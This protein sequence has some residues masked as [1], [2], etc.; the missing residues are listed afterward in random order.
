[1][2]KVLSVLNSASSMEEKKS[3]L[4][5]LVGG[6]MRSVQDG[7]VPVKAVVVEK[8]INCQPHL[9]Y[10]DSN[11]MERSALIDIGEKTTDVSK[12]MSRIRSALDGMLTRRKIINNK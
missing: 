5:R 7:I 12:V 3:D 6:V 2:R 9:V 4:V 1:M 11:G 10:V 8:R